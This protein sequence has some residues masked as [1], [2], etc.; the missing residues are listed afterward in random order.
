M[1]VSACSD[2]RHSRLPVYFLMNEK[3]Q[4]APAGTGNAKAKRVDHKLTSSFLESETS[5]KAS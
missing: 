4:A 5:D 1:T 2:M 3:L